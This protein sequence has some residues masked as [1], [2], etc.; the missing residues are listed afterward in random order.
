MVERFINWTV[1]DIAPLHIRQTDQRPDFFV[2]GSKIIFNRKAPVKERLL[3]VERPDLTAGIAEPRFTVI[4]PGHSPLSAVGRCR[5]LDDIGALKTKTII[6]H[7][8]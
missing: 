4:I 3:K 6:V 8:H 2:A 5:F 7:G 1:T